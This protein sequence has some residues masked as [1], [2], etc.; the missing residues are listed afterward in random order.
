MWRRWRVNSQGNS[1]AFDFDRF[2]EDFEAQKKEQ[3]F[4]KRMKFVLKKNIVRLGEKGKR[5]RGNQ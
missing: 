4:W 3:G 1:T 2:W 5:K